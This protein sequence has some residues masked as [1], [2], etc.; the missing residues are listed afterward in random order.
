MIRLFILPSIHTNDFESNKVCYSH[1]T[2][3]RFRS[4]GSI[5]R[6]VFHYISYYSLHEDTQTDERY[7]H[8][9]KRPYPRIANNQF[10]YKTTRKFCED[11]IYIK[12]TYVSAG[13]LVVPR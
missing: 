11:A 1:S 6:K 2:F 4:Y 8:T 7:N 3:N 9:D 13:L 10:I 5:V 12:L